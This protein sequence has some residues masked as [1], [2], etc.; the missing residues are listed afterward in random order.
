[1]ANDFTINRGDTTTISI[2]VQDENGAPYDLTGATLYLSAKT[3]VAAAEYVFAT[4]SETGSITITP[5]ASGG[6]AVAKILPAYTSGLE[7]RVIR[8]VWG[9]QLEANGDITTIASGTL[10][11]IP[12]VTYGGA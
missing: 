3:D 9:L 11:V 10:Q 6:A 8:L 7:S 5:P 1:M 4:D 2:V 12:V